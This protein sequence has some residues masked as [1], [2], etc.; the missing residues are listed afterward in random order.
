MIKSNLSD[1]N[2]K[3]MTKTTKRWLFYSAVVIFAL[4]SYVII[5]YAQGYKYS[6]SE[7]KFFRTGS[8]FLKT[9]EDAEVFLNNKFLNSTS[10]FGS[11]YTISRLL[12]GQYTVRLERDNFSSWQK[13]IVVEEGLVSDYSRIILLSKSGD[14]V[15]ALKKE[16]T[17]LLY[18]TPKPTP[19]FSPSV[20]PTP[21][22]SPSKT[23]TPTPKPIE[24][25]YVKNSVL[26]KTLDNGEIERL[27]Y[28]VAGFSISPDSKK[29]LWWN[30]SE[31]WVVWLTDADYQPYH[32][33]GDKELITKFSVKIKKADWFR[34]NDHIVVDSG[35]YKVTEID[36]RGG[37]NIIE[38]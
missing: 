12:P 33:T 3:D 35:G 10:F 8:V 13:K 5:L 36:K 15:I 21:K 16:I 23:P 29:L 34:D 25:F 19:T 31:L 7:A 26:F 14:E 18:P 32:K 6:F 1:L 22:I 11:S 9:N 2:P 27:A 37:L 24:P 28:F 4:S 17:N 30:E 38:I 20:K